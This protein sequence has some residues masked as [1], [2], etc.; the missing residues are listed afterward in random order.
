MKFL[1]YSAMLLA[2]A[3]AANL[4]AMPSSQKTQPQSKVIFVVAAVDGFVKQVGH[5]YELLLNLN[6][7]Q[8][9]LLFTDR[10]SRLVKYVKKQTLN[11]AWFSKSETHNFS[12]DAPNAVLS[13]QGQLPSVITITKMHLHGSHAAFFFHSIK[14]GMFT[15]PTGHVNK[16]VLTIDNLTAKQKKLDLGLVGGI[17]GAAVVGGGVWAGLSTTAGQRW[18]NKIQRNMRE[19]KLSKQQQ[20]YSDSRSEV[21]ERNEAR[22]T[23]Q[24]EQQKEQQ[25]TDE[26][27][28]V[29]RRGA[30]DEEGRRNKEALDD[31][32]NE[33]DDDAPGNPFG[34]EATGE[35][36][37][38]TLGEEVSN[39]ALSRIKRSGGLHLYDNPQERSKPKPAARKAEEKVTKEEGNSD[40]GN[41]EDTVG[42]SSSNAQPKKD[43]PWGYEEIDEDNEGQSGESGLLDA[44][45]GASSGG[46][47]LISSTYGQYR[48]TNS[49]VEALRQ[50]DQDEDSNFYQ[51]MGRDRTKMTSNADETGADG[52]D[53]GG[54]P[55]EE[56]A[57]PES[58]SLWNKVGGLFRRAFSKK[59]GVAAEAGSD[60]DDGGLDGA[61]TN[62]GS[63]IGD[64]LE[65][66]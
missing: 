7:V 47:P 18:V 64:E 45:S 46:K 65:D 24:K 20:G 28:K 6:S 31:E 4:A 49:R 60:A 26:Q 19:A 59:S 8:Q 29:N 56:I 58:N 40:E 32:G 10:P 15:I 62:G 51:N 1:K 57:S 48:G 36:G 17:G 12:Q 3:L 42:A 25:E 23:Q 14:A 41:A 43:D 27:N 2:V 63:E 21:R 53:T 66:L 30:Q 33:S 44:D 38:N 52:A 55:E 11:K 9:T 13:T 61:L 37:E 50:R 5:S 22:K 39:P 35:A 34:E 16:V 54:A